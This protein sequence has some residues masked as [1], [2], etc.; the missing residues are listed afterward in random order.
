MR[1]C[2]LPFQILDSLPERLRF[3]GG[4]IRIAGPGRTAAGARSHETQV[5]AGFAAARAAPRI[6]LAV[7]FTGGLGLIQSGNI[8][9]ARHTQH[10]AAP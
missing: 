1:F 2:E 7:H 6:H 3:R 4:C 10:C 8:I 9:R 5:T